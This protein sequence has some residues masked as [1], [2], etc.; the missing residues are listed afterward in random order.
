[1]ATPLSPEA[2]TNVSSSEAFSQCGPDVRL[3]VAG[4]SWVVVIGPSLVKVSPG[5]AMLSVP[6]AAPLGT[7]ALISVA[8]A[9]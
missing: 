4:V 1:V 3:V 6:V 2:T 7:S 5:Q 9:W 8:L